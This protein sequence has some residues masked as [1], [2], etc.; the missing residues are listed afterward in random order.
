[1]R[2][3][4]IIFCDFSS[5]GDVGWNLN[6]IATALLEGFD[7]FGEKYGEYYPPVLV[8]DKRG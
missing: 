7:E 6:D 5:W 1:M 3:L 2:S 4:A 8:F